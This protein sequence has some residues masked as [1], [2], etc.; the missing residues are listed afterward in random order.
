MS[1]I[2]AFD[3]DGV[4]CDSIDECLL[5]SYYAYHK[6]SKIDKFLV[7]ATISGVAVLCFLSNNGIILHKSS[8]YSCCLR[9]M[10]V[11]HKSII[12]LS[13]KFANLCTKEATKCERS[14]PKWSWGPYKLE[15]QKVE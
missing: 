9:G 11:P 15:G 2:V 3:F 8:T 1:K 10:P 14:S 5:V 6:I 7:G 13:Q 12:L 4:I